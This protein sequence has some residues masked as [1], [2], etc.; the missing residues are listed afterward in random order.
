M[1]NAGADIH[2][3]FAHLDGHNHFFQRTVAR[4]LTDAV[5]GAFDLTRAG[6]DRS[7]GVADG[8]T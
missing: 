1:I 5:H 3:V 6:V 4:A 7:D 2:N 8:Q